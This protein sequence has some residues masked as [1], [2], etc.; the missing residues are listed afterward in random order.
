MR[1]AGERDYCIGV[2]GLGAMGQGIAQ[3][4]V[5]GGMRTLLHDAKDGAAV[6]GR[7]Q[8]VKRLDRLVEKQR[9][10]ADEAAAMKGNLVLADGIGDFAACDTVVEAVVEDLDVKH[11][12]FADLEAAVDDRAILASNTSSIPI[13]AIARGCR[14][15]GRVAG[16]HFFNPV[17]LMRLVEVIKGPG[18][19]Q[20]VCDR[21]SALGERMGRTPVQVKD[22][23]GFLVNFGGRAFTTEGLRLQHEGV[24]SPAQIDAILRDGCGFRMGP[25]ELM[26]LTGIDVNFPVS[27]IVYEGYMHDPRIAT[28]PQHKLLYEAGRYGRKSGRGHFEYDEAGKRTDADAADYAPRGAAVFRAVTVDGDAAV[29]R[30]ADEIGLELLDRDDGTSPLIACPVGEDATSFAV[31]TGADPRRLV[32]VDLSA[33]TET[34]V[35]LMT[36]PGSDRSALDG[37]AAAIAAS[38]R[39]VT[40]INDSP[41]FVA[42]RMRAAIGNLGCYMAQ[43]GLAAPQQIDLALKL[44]LNY[45]MGPLEMVADLGASTTLAV[46]QQLQSIT[47]EDRYRPCPWLRRRAT[48]GL[49]IH[50]P[51]GPADT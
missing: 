11:K 17:P 47:G 24:A 14:N 41:G 2:V 22:A 16:M 46:L 50:T 1:G 35:T 25:F 23:P 4:A 49:D 3:V 36:V 19:A 37:L 44:G 27:M 29:C 21:L 38:G 39:S 6:A 34:R 20:E 33:R 26:D 15:P 31:R 5:T 43:I 7:T 9:L 51:D 42:Q 40:A 18:T 10:S 13:G 8:V 28:A 32:A 45:P 30:F 12:V 48:L